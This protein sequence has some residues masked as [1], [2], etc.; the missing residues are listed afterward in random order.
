ML[1]T[2]DKTVSRIDPRTKA[3]TGRFK[4]RGV[5]TDIAAGEGAL[6][7]GNGG[8]RDQPATT[9]SAS[10][11]SIP[12]P[13]RSPARSSCL[14]GRAARSPP[15][16][17]GASPTSPSGRARSGRSTPTAPSPGSIPTTGKLVATIDVDADKIAAGEE[18]VW[19]LKGSVVTRI[20]PRTNRVGQTIRIGTKARHGDRGGRRQGLG[21]GAAGGRRVADRAGA[22]S[23]H[24]HDRRR[25]RRHVH[26]LRRGRG[27]DRQLRRR[28]RLADR[29]RT[30]TASRRGS[31]SAPRRRSRP[32]PARRG[33]ARRADP[34]RAPC[35]HRPAASSSRAA[36]SPTS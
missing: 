4:T 5:P 21:D 9:P 34:G 1:N 22:E 25:R 16:S 13:A 31:R 18:G 12:R 29:P 24:E 30:R 8:G 14:T 15:R 10:R 27:L 28:H 23:R 35:R 3:V 2:Q 20:D 26:R 17:T 6:W 32:A 19:F 7:V 33:S 36:E 11:A